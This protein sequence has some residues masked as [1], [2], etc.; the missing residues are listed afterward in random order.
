LKVDGATVRD[1]RTD[2]QTWE[3]IL[4]RVLS[5]KPHPG[6]SVDKTSFEVLL[7]IK[8]N[9]AP[10]YVLEEGGKD[11]LEVDIGENPVFVLGDHIGL[12]KTVETFALR[13]GEKIS[14]GKQPYLAASCIT[15]LN[16]MLDGKTTV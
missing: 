13:F 6:V 4:R 15:I 9:E 16:Y 2:Q 1:V 14:I 7:K 3:E 8:A 5:R 10:I 11:F 12:P